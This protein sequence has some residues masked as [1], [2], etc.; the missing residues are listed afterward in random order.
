M[1]VIET[2]T[3]RLEGTT[4]ESE[5][6]AADR[7]VQTEFAYH[8]PGLARR[9]T[10]RGNDGEWIV[11]DLWASAADA[12][13]CAASRDNDAIPAAFMELVDGSTVRTTRYATLD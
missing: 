5:F 3:F 2:M 1:A 4:D 6:S 13:A 12:D 9:T 10:A 11:I 7:R 8:Q